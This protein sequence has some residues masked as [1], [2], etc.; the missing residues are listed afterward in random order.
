MAFA[1]LKQKVFHYFVLFHYCRLWLLITEN[2][3]KARKAYLRGKIF[4]V[5]YN[6]RQP[7]MHM[8]L[9]V[10]IYRQT[11]LKFLNTLIKQLSG[12]SCTRYKLQK[13]SKDSQ[14]KNVLLQIPSSTLWINQYIQAF[15]LST[16]VFFFFF[17]S[18]FFIQFLKI[19]HHLHLLQNIDCLPHVVQ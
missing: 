12:R 9:W 5:I 13:I 8:S 14:W 1:F 4:H 18:L 6:A 19:T 10:F 2:F 7:V 15:D 16:R 17:F 3:G 11:T